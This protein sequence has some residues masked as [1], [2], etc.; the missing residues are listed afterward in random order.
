MS[1][2]YDLVIFDCDGTLVDSLD[3]IV[4]SVNLALVEVGLE[5]AL[6]RERI[7]G[8]VGLSLFEAMSVLLPEYSPEWRARAVAAYKS[9]Y[10]RLAD[11][12]ELTTPLFPGVRAT[13]ESLR[14][15]GIT[16]A[17]ATGK[18]LRGLERTV[19]EQRLQGFFEVLMTSD[20]APS[21]PH[22]AM[23]EQILAATGAAA[24]R[25]LMV[26][27]TVFDLEMGRHARVETAAVTFGCH[28]RR[29]LAEAAPD[30]WLDRLPE[31]LPIVGI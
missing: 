24:N 29:R 1:I 3:G 11:G 18:S 30:H 25:S 20:H 6:P 8:V 10:Q 2:R 31:L 15:H 22:P 27:D 4:R 9:H 14:D 17:V 7:A 5:E 21:K 13:L 28:D 19:R 23:I 26:G 12:G 16:M